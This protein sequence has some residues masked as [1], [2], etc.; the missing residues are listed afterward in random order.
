MQTVA[1]PM[2]EPATQG[3]EM[4]M[5]PERRT[6]ANRS[7]LGPICAIGWLALCLGLAPTSCLNPFPDDQPSSQADDR[8]AVIDTYDP[9]AEGVPGD[10]PSVP[11]VGNGATGGGFADELIEPAG[12]A[13]VVPDAGAPIE[14]AGPDAQPAVVR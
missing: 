10:S 1:L 7:V 9:N 12:S 5:H 2:Q 4:P 13:T 8:A 14:D 3:W 11:S 6:G